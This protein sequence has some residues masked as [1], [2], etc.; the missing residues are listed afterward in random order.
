MSRHLEIDLDAIC[1]VQLSDKRYY[2]GMF[3]ARSGR[4]SC[5]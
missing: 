5:R 3:H 4:S 1:T 2:N